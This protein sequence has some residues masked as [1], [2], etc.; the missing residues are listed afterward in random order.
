MA[1]LMLLILRESG[2][3]SRFLDNGGMRP[4]NYISA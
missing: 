2:F 1:I 3:S 4:D